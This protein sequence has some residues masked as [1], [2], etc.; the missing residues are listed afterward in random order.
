LANFRFFF[1]LAL[2]TSVIRTIKE[3]NTMKKIITPK[4]LEKLA[5]KAIKENKDKE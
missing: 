2:I 3:K 5:N 4:D 1:G